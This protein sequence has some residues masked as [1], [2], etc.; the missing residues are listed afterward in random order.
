MGLSIAI[1]GGIVTFSIVYLMMTF[2]TLVDSTQKIALASS[3]IANVQDA[4][5]QTSIS[6]TSID[7]PISPNLLN[8]TLANN[9]S[10]K[11]WN[12]GKFNIIVTYDSGIGSPVRVSEQ[13]V[14]ENTC[15]SDVGRWCLGPFTNDYQDPGILNNGESVKIKCKLSNTIFSNNKLIRVVF[16]TDNGVVATKTVIFA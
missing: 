16:S 14:Y 4:I 9:G 7:S 8:F 13:L 1:A 15:T 2:P 11:L 5:S 3:R 10:S 6:I 12:Y